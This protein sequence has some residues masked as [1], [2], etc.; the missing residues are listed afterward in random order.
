MKK[1][2][3]NCIHRKF[4][5]E[6]GLYCGITGQKPASFDA[7]LNYE[8][9]KAAIEIQEHNATEIPGEPDEQP[10]ANIE[11]EVLPL[12][13]QRLVLSIGLALATGLALS[14]LWALFTSLTDMQFGIMPVV[15]GILV[16]LVIRLTSKNNSIGMGIAASV[17]A[18]A[19]CFLGD[20]LAN[21]HYI[22]LSEEMDYFETLGAID[23][24]YFFE[25][26]T[27]EFDGMSALFYFVAIFEAFSLVHGKN[28]EE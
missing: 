24:S 19:S 27:L 25:I 20:F 23:W 6:T 9:D 3:S 8:P 26:A 10:T 28:K 18:L 2:C 21:I 13:S 11:A 5:P 14:C 17:I 15:V 12:N 1:D 16:G 7:C 22:A 4:N